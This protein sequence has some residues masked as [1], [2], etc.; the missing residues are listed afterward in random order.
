M[1]THKVT[2]IPQ[3]ITSKIPE[4][5]ESADQLNVCF[6]DSRNF[7]PKHEF[8]SKHA[9]SNFVSPDLEIEDTEFYF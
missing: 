4:T 6:P 1:L 2:C 9:A 5:P 7:L 8:S 3:F